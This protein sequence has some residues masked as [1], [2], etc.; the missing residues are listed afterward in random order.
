[1][2]GLAALGSFPTQTENKL[3]NQV[4]QDADRY[5]NLVK[6]YFTSPFQRY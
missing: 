5:S 2:Y 4:N 3:A 1:V 6:A